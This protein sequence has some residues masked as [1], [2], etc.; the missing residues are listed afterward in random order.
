M[1]IFGRTFFQQLNPKSKNDFIEKTIKKIFN[2]KESNR[3]ICFACGKSSAFSIR[4]WIYPFVIKQENFPNISNEIT[5]CRECALKSFTAY[6]T[7]I[8]YGI[9]NFLSFIVLFADTKENNKILSNIIRSKL[10]TIFI[11]YFKNFENRTSIC[12]PYELLG[13][14]LMDLTK[15]FEEAS[16]SNIKPGAIIAGLN[17]KNKKKI[18]Q[19]LSTVV[20]LSKIIE[21]YQ[22]FREN[23]WSLNIINI[24]PFLIMFYNMQESTTSK[25]N[26]D[27]FIHRNKFFKSLIVENDINWN[28]T[29][30]MLFYNIKNKNQTI[31]F[32]D[33]FLKTT[34]EV[35]NL[36]YKDLYNNVSGL[37]YNIGHALYEANSDKAKHFL[38]ELRR[39]RKME[40]FLDELNLI[41][42]QI[43]TSIDV[44][45]FA[46]NEKMFNKLRVFFLIGMANGLFKNNKI[47]NKGDDET[48]D[49]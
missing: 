37:G 28:A 19:T 13:L 25:S 2:E 7:A 23:I 11:S 9:N 35:F 21:L 17:I 26:R 4:S 38:F 44:R 5:L 29:E 49:K 33:L 3:K 48:E 42:S 1:T 30:D 36:D 45:P 41:Q 40:E 14:I 6:T 20:D 8:F 39:K 12:Y 47:K 18:Y 34:L 27:S 43:E 31:P 15:T 22:K 24:D 16:Y 46:N 32:L 10:Q